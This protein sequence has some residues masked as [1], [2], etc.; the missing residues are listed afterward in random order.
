MLPWESI[1]IIRMGKEGLS[2]FRPAD[3]RFSSC[4][5]KPTNLTIRFGSAV[6]RT[7]LIAVS[8]RC[9][10]YAFERRAFFIYHYKLNR[11]D[12]QEK[13]KK[14]NGAATPDDSVSRY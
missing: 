8:L 5:S 14:E 10:F 4:A 2:P 9:F 12:C 6:A 7:I 3:Y 11:I 1:C 13:T